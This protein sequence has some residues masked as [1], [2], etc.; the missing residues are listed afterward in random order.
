V[1]PTIKHRNICIA[2]NLIAVLFLVSGRADLGAVLLLTGLMKFET[3]VLARQ[4]DEREL[5]MQKEM[6]LKDKWVKHHQASV[7]LSLR[8]QHSMEDVIEQLRKK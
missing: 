8:K 5:E 6:T 4:Y 3:Y 1:I 2:I 7:E